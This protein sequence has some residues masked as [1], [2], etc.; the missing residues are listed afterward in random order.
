MLVINIKEHLLGV[1]EVS[2]GKL[3]TFALFIGVVSQSYDPSP[4]LGGRLPPKASS[5]RF[6]NPPVRRLIAPD[7]SIHDIVGT[8]HF[9]SIRNFPKRY[10]IVAMIERADVLIPETADTSPY[11]E[12]TATAEANQ[13]RA[14]L[15]DKEWRRLLEIARMFDINEFD[16][17][18]RYPSELI[19]MVN[20][21]S[22]FT[23]LRFDLREEDGIDFHVT[24]IGQEQGKEI[25]P[26]EDMAEQMRIQFEVNEKLKATVG[27]DE[28]Q[29]V[30]S[31]GG[32]NALAL[33]NAYGNGDAERALR[34]EGIVERWEIWKPFFNGRNRT[35][36]D[37]GII[38]ENCVQGRRCLIYVGVGH[39]FYGGEGS[40]AQLLE[41]EG[42]RLSEFDR[43]ERKKRKK[44]SRR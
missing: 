29:R 10:D 44:R 40:L 22:F 25:I 17:N 30:L 24:R 26:L 34:I 37:R 36:I 18:R 8:M 14:Q 7:G 28:L 21:A 23:S 32:K 6:L 15:G 38:Q 39:L 20:K 3:V 33:F 31:S 4:A 13:V 41:A 27:I 11:P 1:C 35:W 43:P 42:F 19:E 9:A 2:M 16:L 12:A 5:I